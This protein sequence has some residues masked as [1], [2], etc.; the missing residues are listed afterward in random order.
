MDGY[1]MLSRG[2]PEAR[3]LEHNRD[4]AIF[5][6]LSWSRTPGLGLAAKCLSSAGGPISSNRCSRR[7]RDWPFSII[8]SRCS[9]VSNRSRTA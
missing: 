3:R 4:F 8:N 7:F 6:R 5:E 2:L 9:A 1:S